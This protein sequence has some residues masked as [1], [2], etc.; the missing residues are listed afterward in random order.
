[1][2]KNLIREF[3][4]IIM[5]S[6]GYGIAI[7]ST[8]IMYTLLPIL[9]SNIWGP[10]AAGIGI[11]LMTISQLFII[12]PISAAFVDK[13]S[14]RKT[15]FIYAGA[16]IV[17]AALWLASYHTTNITLT[18][19][20][21][22]LMAFCFSIGFGCKFVDVYTL[23][24]SSSSRSGI[25]F[26]ILVTF[27][28]LGRF[29]GTLVQPYLIDTSVQFRAPIIMIIAMI[30]FMGILIFIKD[31]HISSLSITTL[32]TANST[33]I[34]KIKESLKTYKESF[35]RGI[36]FIKRCNYFPLI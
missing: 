12:S 1:M 26:G 17:G 36:I 15:L 3:R 11:M 18:S 6:S 4:N 21:I 30:L 14:A 2:I 19:I 24:M 10:E 23:R 13:F 33:V 32:K 16:F 35:R 29:L 20:L 9:L 7:F 34:E 8:M 22:I 5:M 27:A 28:G 25:A 31:D